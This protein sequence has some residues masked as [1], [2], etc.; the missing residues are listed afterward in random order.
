MGIMMKLG[1]MSNVIKLYYMVLMI[2]LIKVKQKYFM[3]KM[4][5]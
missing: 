4:K 3:I 2:V 5:K 1:Y